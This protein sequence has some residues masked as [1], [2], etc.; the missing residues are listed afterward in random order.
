M[1]VV[2]QIGAVVFV[3]LLLLGMLWVLSRR[4][5]VGT[6][7]PFSRSSGRLEVLDRLQVTPH[8]T[9]VLVRCDERTVLL[10]VHASGSTVIRVEETSK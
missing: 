3:L 7:L 4:G 10:S 6:M 9:L 8:A 5:L 2:S 1:D